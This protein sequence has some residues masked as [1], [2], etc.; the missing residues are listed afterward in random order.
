MTI[1]SRVGRS[2]TTC[3]QTLEKLRFETMSVAPNR[4]IENALTMNRAFSMPRCGVSVLGEIVIF[5]CLFESRID[6]VILRFK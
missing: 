3:K 5:K 6:I 2:Y 4:S 1:Q